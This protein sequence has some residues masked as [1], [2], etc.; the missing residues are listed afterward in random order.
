MNMFK[1]RQE[2]NMFKARQE[3]NDKILARGERRHD[4][5][6][7]HCDVFGSEGWARKNSNLVTE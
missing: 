5:H 6:D 4:L 2:T 7:R 3:T 1:A